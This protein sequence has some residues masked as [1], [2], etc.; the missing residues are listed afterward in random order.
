VKSKVLS[1]FMKHRELVLSGL[2]VIAAIFLQISTNGIFLS[3]ANLLAMADTKSIDAFV[4]IGVTY[5][6]IA[7]EFDLSTASCMALSGIV[8]AWLMVN[9]F[10]IPISIVLV[11]GAGAA[12]GFTNGLLVTQFNIPS[13]IATL[14]TMLAARSLTQV[15]GQGAPVA[16]LPQDFIDIANFRIAG[17]PWTLVL[18]VIVVTVLQYLLKRQRSLFKLFYIGTNEKAAQMVGIKSKKQRWIMFVVSSTIA[19]FSG[20]VMTSKARS[21][22][23]IAF[24]GMELRFIAASV[25]GGA[26]I[27]GGQGS[28]LGAVLGFLVITLIS[29]TMTQ[30]GIS[31]YWEG[32]IFGSILLAA[33]VADQVSQMKKTA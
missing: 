3:T 15:V 32:V 6:L 31:P 9:G 10:S 26:S 12:V 29:N 13:F 14:G 23:P 5:L 11:F 33:A 21:A 30:L 19:A 1:V 16:F 2:I 25:I 27:S 4:V 7:K 8:C 22:S 18:L 28:I 20:I 24:Q 17:M